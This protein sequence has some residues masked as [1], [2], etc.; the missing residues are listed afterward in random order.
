MG[1]S[2]ITLQ[3]HSLQMLAEIATEH[4]S[5]IVSPL[6]IDLFE[7][8]LRQDG[9]RNAGALKSGRRR[10]RSEVAARS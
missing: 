5:T 4:N 6:P 2:A 1:K 3:F 9:R 7:P 8:F 10:A